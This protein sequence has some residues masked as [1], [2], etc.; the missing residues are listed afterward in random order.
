[1]LYDPGYQNSENEKEV[2]SITRADFGAMGTNDF[3]ILIDIF[4]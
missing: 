4:I 2:K 1:V 3:Y